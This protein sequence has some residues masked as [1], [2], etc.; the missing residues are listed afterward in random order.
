VTAVRRLVRAAI[1]LGLGLLVVLGAAPARAASSSALAVR[2]LDT[3]S[4]P[5]VRL[6]VQ[7]SGANA[8]KLT[9]FTV[10]NNGQIV[11]GVRVRP[12]SE[13]QTPVGVVLVIDTSGSMREQGRIEAAKSAAETFV[14][15][16]GPTEKVAVVAFSDS[17]LVVHPFSA[18][19][20]AAGAVAGLQPSGGTA[21]WD[22]V[23]LA[24][25]LFADEPN[26]QPNIVVLSDGADSASKTTPE[27]ARSAAV[28]AHAVVHTVGFGSTA[29]DTAGLESLARDTGGQSLVTTSTA[30]VADLFAAVRRSL[31]EQ[32]E[33]TWQATGDTPLDLAI[34]VPDAT[35]TARGTAGSIS[36]AGDTQPERVAP[37]STIARI[38][39]SAGK[40]L[41]ILSAVAVAIIAVL[42]LGMYMNNPQG[43]VDRLRAYEGQKTVQAAVEGQLSANLATSPMTHKAIAAATAAME[44]KG[45]LE[46]VERKLDEARLPI[47]AAEAAFFAAAFAFLLAL[48][49]FFLKG[50][51]MAVIAFAAGLGIPA[52]VVSFL[53][54]NRKR[55][56]LRQLPAMLQL[57]ASS[58]RAGYALLQGCEA[59]AREIEDPMGAELRRVLAEARLGRS[60]D[61]ALEEMALR[62]NSDDFSWVVMAISI[63]RNVGGNLA[64]LLD[65]VADTMQARTRLRREVKALTAE[66][67][68]SA[69][70]LVI[71]PPALML[72]MK[73][74][75]PGYLTPLFTQSAGKIMLG[76]GAFLMVAG[77]FWMQKMIKVDV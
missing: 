38:A 33:L 41:A 54:W 1:A 69:I 35:T 53:G 32:F 6:T 63:Q 24:A 19:N 67:R 28:A 11:N 72:A 64:E 48:L 7:Y 13:T 30:G 77:W 4:W 62:M 18:D 37:P 66:G 26:V 73:F 50:P 10:R 61:D 2:T 58:L 65:T 45:V 39:Q 12:L 51:V 14:E 76:T 68:M 25:G 55:K 17:P 22:A 27:E 23:R 57:L 5:N 31:D 3:T 43:L 21:L 46:W 70:M 75:S 36:H 60:L 47:R 59:V 20:G 15:G 9:D 8:P 42:G 44:G 40:P 74:L 52:A 56:F 34:S 49:T 16:R 71:M 29:L